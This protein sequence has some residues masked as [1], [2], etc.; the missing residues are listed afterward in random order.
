[1]TTF[2]IRRLLL[3]PLIVLGV[4]LI[5]FSLFQILGP[6][7]LL[8]SYVNPN[9]FDKLS[10]A[11]LDA[12]KEKYGL[13]KP[14]VERYGK[15]LFNALKGDLGW[16]QVGKEPVL[17]AIWSRFPYTFELA[18]Y[19]LFPVVGVGIWLGVM[20][21]VKRDKFLDHFIR[22]VAII[23]WSFPD[24]V[25]G[26]LVLMVFYSVL[27]WFPP[28]NLSQWAE[29]VV[30]SSSFIKATHLLTI[31]ALINGRL[32]IFWDALRHII[33]PVMTL[34]FLWW[35]YLLRITRSSMLE[36]LSKEYVRTARAKGVPE[37]E[38]I[39]K[40]AKRNAM[41]PVVTVAGAMVIG[42]L[43]G[44]VII[45]V[46]FNRTGIGRLAAEA[47]VALDYATVLGTTLFYSTLLVLGNLIIDIL[48]AV[49][50]PR[51]RLG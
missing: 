47:A 32:D 30:K 37:K 49:F 41:I 44:T 46:I 39:H 35:A 1:M 51:V 19:A 40:H 29:E 9:V 34:S 23:G 42:L 14:F 26:L 22:I 13:N 20:A 21:A 33:G 2:I 8:A 27:G 12:L 16:S 31:D 5:I 3:L 18:L 11:E 15:W 4:S 48:Y 43:S 28:G 24:F 17:K 25:F 7:K 50:D 38:V 10:N 36:V 6:D 45:E